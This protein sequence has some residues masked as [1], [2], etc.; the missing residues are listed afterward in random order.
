MDAIPEATMNELLD[1]G[2]REQ[3]LLWQGS[4]I[5][6]SRVLW[7]PKGKKKCLTITGKAL[8]PIIRELAIQGAEMPL[9]AAFG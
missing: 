8:E 5:Y 4:L 7:R 1:Y 9:K 6:R 2:H 3:S